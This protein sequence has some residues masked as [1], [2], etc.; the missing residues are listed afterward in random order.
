MNRYTDE[1]VELLLHKPVGENVENCHF[2]IF[3]LFY[4]LIKPA[5]FVVYSFHY[6]HVL[7]EFCSCMQ[8]SATTIF[9]CVFLCPLV[10]CILVRNS[11]VYTRLF[12]GEVIVWSIFPVSIRCP[13]EIMVFIVSDRRLR[14]HQRW[15]RKLT[16]PPLFPP[17]SSRIG[18]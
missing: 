9:L 13:A 7:L 10:L 3:I 16:L 1:Q 12:L 15:R 2:G 18:R 5:L 8:L 17:Q 4:F 6:T 11:V 14:G